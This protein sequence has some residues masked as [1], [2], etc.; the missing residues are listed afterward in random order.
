MCVY[1]GRARE[2]VRKRDNEVLAR[3]PLFFKMI[4]SILLKIDHQCNL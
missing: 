2:R 1:G 4:I 3:N